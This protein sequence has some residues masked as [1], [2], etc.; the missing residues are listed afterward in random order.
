MGFIG[1]A[2]AG[3]GSVG[4]TEF[5]TVGLPVASRGQPEVPNGPGGP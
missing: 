2:G 3:V 5:G 1:P 4:A